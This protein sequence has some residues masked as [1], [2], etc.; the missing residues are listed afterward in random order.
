MLLQ[1]CSYRYRPENLCADAYRVPPPGLEDAYGLHTHA[2]FK[3]DSRQEMQRTCLEALLVRVFSCETMVFPLW[4]LVALIH[5]VLAS[6]LLISM[7]SPIALEVS[8]GFFVVMTH[9]LSKLVYP[10][11]AFPKVRVV[12]IWYSMGTWM[13]LAPTMFTHA[14]LTA[15]VEKCCPCWRRAR[16]TSI[17]QRKTQFYKSQ[18]G[19]V[20]LAATL[21]GLSIYRSSLCLAAPVVAADTCP[22]IG[23]PSEVS[24]KMLPSRFEVENYRCD[25]AVGPFG[26]AGGQCGLLDDD[27]SAIFCYCCCQYSGQCGYAGKP[28]KLSLRPVGTEGPCDRWKTAGALL[29]ASILLVL[30][31]PWVYAV[32]RDLRRYGYVQ[33]VHAQ[34]RVQSIAL[35]ERWA[36]GGKGQ[37]WEVVA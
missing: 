5:A 17:G 28:E 13:G 27:M 31:T 3:K 1:R 25:F 11:I 30:A 35:L 15:F 26:K 32:F 8:T 29:Y 18:L 4:S 34:E 33:G 36:G 6:W 14:M 24:G 12:E 20:G 19:I 23:K 22:A 21:L 10:L 7:E 16:W 37:S 9:M 2:H